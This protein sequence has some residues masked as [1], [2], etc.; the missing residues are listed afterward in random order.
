MH[1]LQVY[2]LGFNKRLRS[3]GSVCGAESEIFTGWIFVTFFADITPCE[4]VCV[5]ILKVSQ[6]L[7]L[8]HRT[9]GIA[10]GDGS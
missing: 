10:G 5:L 2:H 7:S 9:A 8:S 4:H 6:C 1:S 3:K